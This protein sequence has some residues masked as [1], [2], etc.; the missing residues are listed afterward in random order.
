VDCEIK[1]MGVENTY[2]PCFVSQ[3][4]L[5]AEKNH[6]EGFAAEVYMYTCVF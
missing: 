4:A 6:V 2:F 1:K 3:K 5:T